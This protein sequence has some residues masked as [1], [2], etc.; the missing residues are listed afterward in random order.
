MA[1]IR[2]ASAAVNLFHPAYAPWICNAWIALASRPARHGQQRSLRRILHVLNRLEL[3]IRALTGRPGPRVGAVVFLLR[4]R[5][6]LPQVRNLRVI[7][8]PV[9]LV[10]QGDQAC[11]LQLSQDALYPLGFLVV[12]GAGQRPF[13][14]PQYVRT[15]RLFAADMVT[16]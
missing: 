12:D 1:E 3:G 8:S 4:L 5:L 14:S 2:S 6:V 15:E 9:A 11:G 10:G 16:G 13:G 7:A